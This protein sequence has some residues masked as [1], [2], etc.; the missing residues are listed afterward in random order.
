MESETRWQWRERLRQYMHNVP[1]VRLIV[2]SFVVLIVV[3]GLLL[4]TPLCSREH[5]PTNPVDAFFTSCSAVC[6]TGLVPFDT[7]LH[8]NTLGQVVILVL[9]QVGGLGLVTLTT[10][11]TLLLR[12]KMGLRNLK[13]ATENTNGD[14]ANMNELLRL[15]LLFTFTCEFV[16]AVLLMIRFVPLYSGQGVWI[17]V[18]LA[19]SAYCNAGFDILGFLKPC[20]N[21]IPFA[22]DPL[23]CLTIAGLI[24]IGGI[25]FIVISDIYR[26]KLHTQAHR[27]KRMPLSFHSRIVLLV[28]GLLLLVGTVLILLLEY[29]NVTLAGKSF[30]SKVLISFFQ[31]VSARTAGF[32]S[33]DIATELDFTKIVTIL[34]M[35]IGASP[36]GTGGG[37]KTTTL[38]VLI[39]TV[40]AVLHGDEEATFAHRRFEKFTVYRALA[41]AA[42]ALLLVMVAGGAISVLEPQASTVDVFFEVTS[43]FGTVGTSANLT[44]TLSAPS[45]IILIFLMFAGRVGPVSLGMAVSLKHRHES[46]ACVLPEG[47]I[48]VG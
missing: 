1:P 30:G 47:Q 14:A 5:V 3:G 9:I 40:R 6:V 10:G 42:M 4:T 29:N 21:L 17:S 44:P 32:A 15:I 13:L 36:G 24:I 23:V 18:F 37:I 39:C 12:K 33:V 22:E 26:A 45:K 20:G 11:V 28:T 8:W 31:S 46:G 7:Y 25:G 16:G 19:V 2:I 27:Q 38:L 35:F 34:L 48:V 43:A 41:I